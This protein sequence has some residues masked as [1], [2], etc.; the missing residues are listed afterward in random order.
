MNKLY[1][2]LMAQQ[3]LTTKDND[4]NY[5][6]WINLVLMFNDIAKSNNKEIMIYPLYTPKWDK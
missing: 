3:N 5:H 2:D 4:L 6:Q 1:V